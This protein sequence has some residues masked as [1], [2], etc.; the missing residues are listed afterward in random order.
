MNNEIKRIIIDEEHFTEANYPLTI[1]QNFSTLG[2]ITGNS[3]QEPLTTFLP[4]DFIRDLLSFSASTIFEEYNLS[5]KP[6]DFLSFDFVFLDCDIAQG[7][8]FGGKPSEIIHK[9]L[10]KDIHID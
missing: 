9:N 6:S 7:L 1:K 3:R 4:D 10:F 2:S 5:H 8:I